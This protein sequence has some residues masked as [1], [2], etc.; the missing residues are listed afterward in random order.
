MP[1]VQIVFGVHGD[2]WRIGKSF[3]MVFEQTVA[4]LFIVT[5]IDQTVLV[6]LQT[7]SEI[8]NIRDVFTIVGMRI[9][10]HRRG[11]LCG[12][13]APH[14]GRMPARFWIRQF[15]GLSL[16]V[17][18]RALQRAAERAAGVFNRSVSA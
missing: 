8:E 5:R 4:K 15:H 2:K 6:V 3:G 12:F 17:I 18:R 7:L 13:D 9:E 16:F 14:A 1:A 11:L 10:G